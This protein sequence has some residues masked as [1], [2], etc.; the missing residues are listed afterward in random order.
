[1]KRKI[2]V[3]V[4]LVTYTFCFSQEKSAVDSY[5]NYFNL[6]RETLFL[7]TNKTTFLPG[8]EVWFKA[9]AYDRKSQLTSKATT[10]IRVGIFDKDGKQVDQK[11]F[12]AKDGFAHGSIKIDSSF[13]SGDYYL[14]ASTNWMRNFKEDDAFIKKIKVRNPSSE[15]ELSVQTREY[16]IQF[17]PEG[18][19]LLANVKNV[20]GVKV[21]NDLGKGSQ[22]SGVIVDVNGAEVVKFKSNAM[23][24]GRFSFTPTE[25]NTY[26]ALVTLDNTK[27]VELDFPEVEDRGINIQINNLNPRDVV[28]TLLTNNSSFDDIL[29][30]GKYT[31][32]I[33]KDGVTK[34]IPMEFTTTEEKIIISK[35]DLFK[36]VNTV[37]L[38]DKNQ[39]P[40]V[41]RMFFNE[42]PIKNHRISFQRLET[43]NDSLSY[44]FI[45]GTSDNSVLHASVSVLPKGTKSYKPRHNILSAF[46][47]QP[48]V[49]G[50]IENPSYYFTDMDR[51]KRY[52]LDVL[53]L[54]QGWSRYDWND[55]FNRPP[56]MNYTFNNGLTLRG[57]L[58][59]EAK[60]TKEL[61]LFPTVMNKS[62]N[63]KFDQDGKFEINNFMPQKDEYLV[64]TAVTNKE[65]TKKPGLVVNFPTPFEKE[66][67]DVSEYQNFQSFYS[68]K[69][70]A[71]EGFVSSGRKVLD[72]VVIKAQRDKEKRKEYRLKTSGKLHN[73][74]PK[75]N[76]RYINLAQF[77]ENQ[78][79]DTNPITEQIGFT[80]SIN[81][82]NGSANSFANNGTDTNNDNS[83]TG[84]TTQGGSDANL[85]STAVIGSQIR[86]LNPSRNPVVFFLNNVQINDPAIVLNRPLFEFE[87][88]YIDA[89]LNTHMVSIGANVSTFATVIKLFTRRTPFIF[90]DTRSP[91]ENA[92][93]VTYGFEATKTFYTPK[94][95][96]FDTE[97]FQDMGAIHWTPNFV[98][99]N[100][101]ITELNTLNTGLNEVTFYIEGISSNGDLIS[102]TLTVNS[103]GN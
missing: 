55:V 36:G 22:A 19:H 58:N 82:G 83:A 62:R 63:I 11:L 8:E 81:S 67:I 13:V 31:L 60:L 103:E 78:G 4:F 3:L 12:L 21:V 72:E 51:K 76:R 46:Y 5:V 23:G 95:G 30:H 27:E 47:L 86:H 68:N 17:L 52:E 9:Y 85:T 59:D 44:K 20:V 90:N 73:V 87:D 96:G 80:T 50:Y 6:P 28:I 88:I 32:L 75:M 71:L 33:H 35:S 43:V 34:V 38:F 91:N 98:I 102:Q 25:R 64:F 16:D 56:Q 54:T 39:K 84:A 15:E 41:E 101:K 29:D 45:T 18:G 7:H 53:L 40:I 66:S 70:S 100:N 1:M 93:K 42:A 92:V 69:N 99:S 10:N 79:F 65:K 2:A 89:T 94:Y 26:K 48:Y 49:K 37:T 57:N 77:L 74:T 61:I 14:R 97:L 24:L